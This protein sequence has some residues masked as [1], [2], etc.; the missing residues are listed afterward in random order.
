MHKLPV[1]F[2]PQKADSLR[3][4]ACHKKKAFKMSLK[5]NENTKVKINEA[6][7]SLLY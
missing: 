6:S 4:R 5:Q 1:I 7:M 3:S 2:Q